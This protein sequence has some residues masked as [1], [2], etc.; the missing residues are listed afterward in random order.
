MISITEQ[1]SSLLLRERLFTEAE[2]GKF[3]AE[4]KAAGLSLDLYLDQKKL[5]TSADLARLRSEIFTVPLVSMHERVVPKEILFIIPLEVAEHYQMLAFELLGT[6]VSVAMVNPGDLRAREA[7]EFIAR[8]KG[9]KVCY[10]VTTPEDLDELQKQYQSLQG[11]AG[12]AAAVEA[13]A[14]ATTQ[15][16]EGQ[17]APVSKIVSVI[18]KNAVEG[19]AS[20]IHIE[21]TPQGT[22]VR[23]RVDGVL[24]TTLVLPPHL[25]SSIISRVKVLANLK[26]DETRLPQDGRIR[27]NIENHEYDF[28]ISTLPLLDQEKVVMRILDISRGPVPLEELGFAGRELE[29]IKRS[30]KAPYGMFLV[31]GPTGSGKSTTL[32]SVLKELNKEGVNIS[33]LEDPVE[34][35]LEPRKSL[36]EQREVGRDVPD[37][38]SLTVA[39]CQQITEAMKGWLAATCPI[40]IASPWPNASRSPKR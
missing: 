3:A 38:D 28:R 29:I 15:P 9:L 34:Y 4:T 8:G 5:I 26:I 11:V 19:G 20:D 1:L 32:F 16:E 7:M 22:R 31:V 39:E 33:T 2:I 12:E 30:I 40:W 13:K 25:H 6:E 27:L 23:Y 14:A 10:N 17:V 37:L 36:V 24:H 18:F 35:V 21:P